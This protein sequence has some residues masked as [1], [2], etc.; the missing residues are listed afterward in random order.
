MKA[1][2]NME[3]FLESVEAERDRYREALEE[4]ANAPEWVSKATSGDKIYLTYSMATIDLA[5]KALVET[6]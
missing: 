2:S 3:D 5:R 4:I 6:T 1:T